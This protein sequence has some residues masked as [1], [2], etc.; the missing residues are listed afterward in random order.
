LESRCVPYAVS[1]GAWPHPQ[2]VTISFVPDGT[3]LGSN[4]NGYIYSNLFATLNAHT[5]WS[6]AT[7]QKQILKAAASWA[8]EANINF[9]VVPDD[10]APIGSGLFQQGDPGMGDI[11]I[12]GYNFN[13]STLAMADMPPPLNNFSLAGDITFNTGQPWNIGS[14]YDLFSVAAHEIGHTLGLGESSVAQAVMY[15]VY[16]GARLGLGSDDVAGIQTIYGGARSPDAFDAAS[17]NNSLTTASNISSLIDPV[18]L[19]ALLSGDLTSTN[20]SSGT[21]TTTDVDYY[22]FAAP[23]QTGCTMTVQ[24]QTAGLSLLAPAVTV[25]A[26]DQVTVLGCATGTQYGT[27]VTVTVG[28]V[29]PGEVFYVKV[30]GADTT[31]LGSGKYTLALNFGL[32]PTPAQASLD[33]QTLNGSPQVSGGG[34]PQTSDPDEGPSDGFGSFSEATDGTPRS[35]ATQPAAVSSGPASPAVAQAVIALLNAAPG[36][37]LATFAA[38]PP[39]GP[40]F[41]DFLPPAVLLPGPQASTTT[42]S[43]GLLICHAGTGQEFAPAEADRASAVPMRGETGRAPAQ[44]A[45]GGAEDVAALRRAGDAVFA[46][47]P[48]T[49]TVGCAGAALLS[50]EALSAAPLQEAGAALLAIALGAHLIIPSDQEE[51]KRRLRYQARET[52]RGRPVSRK[53]GG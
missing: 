5:G 31:P 10:G 52:I 49:D 18:A 15:P 53:G 48:A 9:A 39:T 46:A 36:R 45:D 23:S 44:T 38:A 8:Q 22:T 17:S 26:A 21:R 12:G 43:Q 1:G 47:E 28:N 3:I 33:T 32:L 4:S 6:T 7:W 20:G 24:V 40:A 2:L 34:Q 35:A 19:T 11:R 42:G 13:N 25:Y 41:G 29:T 51:R 14:T 37:A 27:T 30:T 16:S 50:G